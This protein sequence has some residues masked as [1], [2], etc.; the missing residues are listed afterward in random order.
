M[1]RV[2]ASE[3][4]R[5]GKIAS[6][7]GLKSYLDQNDFVAIPR[8]NCLSLSTENTGPRET[9][10]AIAQNFQIPVLYEE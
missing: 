4:A 10:A 1:T 2:S 6:P 8:D 7:E 3:R 9:A 5:K